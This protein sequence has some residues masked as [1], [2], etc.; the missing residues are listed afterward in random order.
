MPILPSCLCLS[1]SKWRRKNFHTHQVETIEIPCAVCSVLLTLTV[2]QVET[3]NF[4]IAAYAAN[5]TP[6]GGGRVFTCWW[7][8]RVST[9]GGSAA[10]EN[11]SSPLVA[12]KF[13]GPTCNKHKQDGKNDI[14][15]ISVVSTWRGLALLNFFSVFT[16]YAVSISSMEDMV[17]VEFLSSPPGE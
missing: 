6:S 3:E 7:N 9:Q 15:G 2:Q 8:L 17:F 12:L 10:C 5:R 1:C 14:R 13:S 4:S 11:L 16:S